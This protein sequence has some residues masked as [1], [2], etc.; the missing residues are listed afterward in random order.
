MANDTICAHKILDGEHRG[1]YWAIIEEGMANR[2]IAPRVKLPCGCKLK[3]THPLKDR[4]TILFRG[5]GGCSDCAPPPDGAASSSGAR[6]S[7]AAGRA[8][9]PA[10]PLPPPAAAADINDASAPPFP[11]WAA[12]SGSKKF[13]EVIFVLNEDPD[14]VPDSVYHTDSFATCFPD[15]AADMDATYR[16][17]SFLKGACKDRRSE[18]GKEIRSHFRALRGKRARVEYLGQGGGAA[19]RAKRKRTP[20]AMSNARWVKEDGS[21]VFAKLP[22][23]R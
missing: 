2:G 10:A 1:K 5:L 4:R 16:A 18:V 23:L 11:G 9:P 19:E 14:F 7:N 17:A 12:S 15:A 3:L 20:G 13:A 22:F 8:S 21:R 6:S